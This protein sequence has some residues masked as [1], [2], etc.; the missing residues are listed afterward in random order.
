QSPGASNGAG[1]CMGRGIAA[2]SRT[3]QKY[4]VWMACHDAPYIVRIDGSIPAPMGMDRVVDGRT[5]PAIHV[6]GSAICGAGVDVQQNIWAISSGPAIATRI[7]VDQNGNPTAPDL[8]GS[9][10]GAG[11]PVGKGDFCGLGMKSVDQGVTGYTYSDFTGFGLRNFT[12]PKGE[13]TFV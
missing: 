1:G 8:T 2:D 10:G 6:P 13:Y 9:P 4:W 11:C 7:V 12:T 5:M 3:M